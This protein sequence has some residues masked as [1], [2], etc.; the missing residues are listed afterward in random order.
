MNQPL[1]HS[2]P[3]NQLKTVAIPAH[4]VAATINA[5]VARAVP[6]IKCPAK[7]SRTAL[8]IAT[9]GTKA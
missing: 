8:V 2:H 9:P 7:I 6:L 5:S 1:A 3:P 4:I